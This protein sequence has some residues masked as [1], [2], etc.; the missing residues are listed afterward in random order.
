M[1]GLDYEAGFLLPLVSDLIETRFYMGGYHYDSKL[2][3]NI[4]GITAR[5]EARPT[6]SFVIDVQLKHD[7]VFHTDAYVG[8]YVTLPFSIGN[9]FK[10][11]NPFEGWEESLALFKG[12]RKPKKRIT[13]MVIRDIDVVS[14]EGSETIHVKEH[15]MVY[16]DNSAP[17]GGD[18]SYSHPYNAI[19]GGIN[20]AF[21]DNWVYVREG[22]GNYDEDIVLVAGTTL[23]GSGYNGGFCGISTQGY[24]VIDA[25]GIQAVSM[26]DNTTIMGFQI[27]NGTARGISVFDQTG[28]CISHNNI[29]NNADDGILVTIGAVVVSD[30]LI[31][32]NTFSNNPT[33]DINIVFM[34]NHTVSNF[35]IS[36]NNISSNGQVGIRL[37]NLFPATNTT[38]LTISRNTVANHTSHGIHISNMVGA[39]L[40]N[41]AISENTISGNGND[42]VVID[43]TGTVSGLVFYRNTITANTQDGI[44]LN[45]V[46]GTM[47]NVNL[48]NNAAGSAGYNSIYGNDTGDDPAYFDLAN[49]TGVDDMKAENNWWG[50]AT[51]DAA[52][53]GGANTV[54]YNPSLSSN[55]N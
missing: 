42:G 30:M 9:I 52:Q 16:V 48:G 6:P 44:D 17:A 37:Q 54:D 3:K 34:A 45:N 2:G 40:T 51:P 7:N 32:N 22:N 33:N 46:A 31:A 35:T 19:Q 49:D 1:R 14:S 27:Q 25:E 13:D 15:D 55:P 36:E 5:I 18:G 12:P 26:A 38:N 8:G 20:A 47:T 41:T 21:G 28:W 4:N 39:A 53:F 24:P 11:K 50:Q 29:V 43:S 23:W 10:G